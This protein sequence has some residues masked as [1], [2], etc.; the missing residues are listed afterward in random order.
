MARRW[1]R[2][3]LFTYLN[4][5]AGIA[6]SAV[7]IGWTDSGAKGAAGSRGSARKGGGGVARELGKGAAG[8]R[9][10]APRKGG[11]GVA[12]DRS[13]MG[14]AGSR[15]S[16]RRG[17]TCRVLRAPESVYTGPECVIRP[18]R[19]ANPPGYSQTRETIY[20][21]YENKFIYIYIYIKV[22]ACIT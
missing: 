8:S 17:R 12:R 7:A 5:A 11:G 2:S 19:A 14:A 20:D 22:Y 10:S 9:G 13:E 3:G 15:G 16:A 4:M 21:N 6:G 18:L 1:P